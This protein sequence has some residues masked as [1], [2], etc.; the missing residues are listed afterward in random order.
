[1]RH[2]AAEK[3]GWLE[4]RCLFCFGSRMFLS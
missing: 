2:R 1:V 3:L 4:L